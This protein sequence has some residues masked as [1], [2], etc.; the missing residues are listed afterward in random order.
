MIE[1]DYIEI[2][3]TWVGTRHNKT[4][5]KLLNNTGKGEKGKEE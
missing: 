4:L 1:R 3:H 2:Y 5:S